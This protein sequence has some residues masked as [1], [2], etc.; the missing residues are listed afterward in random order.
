MKIQRFET[1]DV[2]IYPRFTRLVH[3]EGET[4]KINDTYQ[5]VRESDIRNNQIISDVGDCLENGRTPLVL[6]NI[7]M[8]MSGPA[9]TSSLSLVTNYPL[10][11]IHL[12]TPTHNTFLKATIKIGTYIQNKLNRCHN[13]SF[14]M[15]V[16][17]NTFLSAITNS[18]KTRQLKRKIR[19]I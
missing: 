2:D 7:P 8:H 6:R 17:A 4:L 3:S 13:P 11:F 1:S 15:I 12:P 14:A 18:K 9:I 16:C 19:W 5:M 10:A